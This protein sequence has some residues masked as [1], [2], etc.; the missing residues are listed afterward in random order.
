MAVD[1]DT[2]QGGGEK[3]V[4]D[5]GDC[6]SLCRLQG[7]PR[8]PIQH[9]FHGESQE[10]IAQLPSLG[11]AGGTQTDKRLLPPRSHREHGTTTAADEKILL[12]LVESLTCH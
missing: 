10:Q 5:P 1:R 9:H 4:K 3:E 7:S 11:S 8:R 6:I 2:D 12:S